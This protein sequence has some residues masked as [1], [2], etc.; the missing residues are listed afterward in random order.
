MGSTWPKVIREQTEVAIDPFI[1]PMAT[2]FDQEAFIA[3]VIRRLRVDAP[4]EEVVA[5]RPG[6]QAQAPRKIFSLFD[7][8]LA[9]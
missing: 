6:P 7:G 9:Q 3:A 8:R 5:H 2:A 1:V 4:A